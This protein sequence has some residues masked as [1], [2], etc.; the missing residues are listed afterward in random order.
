MS[1]P[2]ASTSLRGSFGRSLLLGRDDQSGLSTLEWLL[3]V[4]AVAGLAALAVT[5]VGGLVEDTTEQIRSSSA[6]I[7][8]AR[9]GA[10]EITARARSARTVEPGAPRSYDDDR[11]AGMCRRLA[12]TYGSAGVVVQWVG[13]GEPLPSATIVPAEEY[14]RQPPGAAP[15]CV[16]AASS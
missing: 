8:A 9:L 7:A 10:Q 11:F 3:I 15:T 6:H 13:D 4:A 5:L 12:I 1:A 14:D 2:H 16:V